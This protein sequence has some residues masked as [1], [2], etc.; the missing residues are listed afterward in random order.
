M[1]LHTRGVAAGPQNH[2]QGGLQK[3]VTDLPSIYAEL[4]RRELRRRRGWGAPRDYANDPVGFARDVLGLTVWSRFSEML[5]AALEHDRVAV[6]AG[7]KVGKSLS[8]VTLALWWALAREGHVLI[9][10]TTHPQVKGIIWRELT[11]VNRRSGLALN[12]PLDPGTGLQLASGATITART[13]ATRENMQ[14]YSGDNVLYLID[15]SSGIQREILEAIEGNMAG[16]GKMLMFGNPTRLSGYYY[17]AFNKNK[18]GWHTITIS[19][20]ESPNVTSET[21]HIPGM[22]LP[23]WIRDTEKQHGKDSDYVKIHIDGE[24]AAG[25]S[26]S[27][28]PLALVDAASQRSAPPEGRLRIGVDVA[29]SGADSTVVYAIRG[30][31]AYP[32]LAARGLDGAGVAALALQAI[33]R[34]GTDQERDTRQRAL[35][36]DDAR[37]VVNVDEIG[38]GASAY[39]HLKGTPGVQVNA[40][41]VAARATSEQYRILRDQLWFAVKDWLEEGGCLPP[42]DDDVREELIAPTYSF[43]AKGRYMVSGKDDIRATLGRSPDGA[44]ALALAVYQP[45]QTRGLRVRRV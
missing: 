7:R 12:L 9:T 11:T 35:M 28:I 39:D 25:A 6:K 4:A 13:A 37:P 26:N 44:D 31:H 29:R 40:V 43:D 45:P 1:A 19:S 8:I 32:P 41:N 5:Q 33:E 30:N 22:A 36:S 18:N 34:Y 24:F 15:E 42:G 2:H 17:D 21:A 38:V 27:V 3:S 20:R 10:S 14:G 23:T 16:G